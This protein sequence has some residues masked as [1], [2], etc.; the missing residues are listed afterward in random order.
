M[1]WGYFKKTD[2]FFIQLTSL[3]SLIPGYGLILLMTDILGLSFWSV[4]IA[5][6]FQL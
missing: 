4:I 2:V 6:V 1:V 3:I 5:V